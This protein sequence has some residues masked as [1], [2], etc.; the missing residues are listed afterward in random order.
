MSGLAISAFPGHGLLN[1]TRG[2]CMP[3][4]R[5]VFWFVGQLVNGRIIIVDCFFPVDCCL[6]DVVHIIICVLENVNY[7]FFD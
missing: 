4:S 7:R 5:H 1:P 3:D 2:C 6:L